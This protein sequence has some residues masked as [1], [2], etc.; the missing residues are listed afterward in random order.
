MGRRALSRAGA[1]GLI[2]VAIAL[3]VG[4]VAEANLGDLDM[5][6]G[7]GGKQTLNLG[8][9]DR[10]TDVLVMSDG[11]LLVV[12]STAATDAGHNDFA[13]GRFTASGA[14]DTSFN[15]SGHVTRGTPGVNDIG[16]GVVV[17]ADGRIVVAGYGGP[18]Q[19]FIAKRLNANGTV[20]G[21]FAGGTG[22]SDIDF[23]G[24]ETMSAMVA[25]PDGKLVLVGGTGGGDFAIVRLNA[26]G[27]PDTTFSGDESRFRATTRRTVRSVS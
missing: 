6:F 26:D 12:G 21:T 24:A 14:P 25:Q 17:Q 4:S 7:T 27:T 18:S 1:A 10:A 9:T 16:G 2:G 23:G 3:L 20:D 19:D 13:I 15:S 22:T 11:R 5:T 8:G